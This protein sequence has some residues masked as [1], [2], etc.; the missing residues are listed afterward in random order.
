MN[1]RPLITIIRD[2]ESIAITPEPA[3]YSTTTTTMID[4]GTSVSGKTLGSVVR[5][6]VARVSLSWKFL[7]PEQWASINSIFKTQDGK[8][9]N[10]TVDVIY[11]DQTLG[12]WVDSPKEMI[13][14]DRSAGMSRYDSKGAIVEGWLDC[15]LELTE[16]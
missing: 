3:S 10:Y 6:A 2:G 12:D 11:Y 13:V 5:E 1:N 4:S 16:V 14:S 8:E 9:S 15:S 7:T